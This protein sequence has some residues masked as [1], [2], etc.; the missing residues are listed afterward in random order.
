MQTIQAEHVVR[1]T[2]THDTG[3]EQHAHIIQAF[4]VRPIQ[5]HHADK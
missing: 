5:P 1:A 4:Q 3:R 2:N